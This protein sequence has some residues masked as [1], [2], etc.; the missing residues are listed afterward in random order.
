[1][2]T[3]LRDIRRRLRLKLAKD[4]ARQQPTAAADDQSLAEIA[5]WGRWFVSAHAQLLEELHLTPEQHFR[6]LAAVT[7]LAAA[8]TQRMRDDYRR[9][10]L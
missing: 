9:R 4:G 6:E 1:M 2:A 3:R 10:Q 8:I 5:A 7:E